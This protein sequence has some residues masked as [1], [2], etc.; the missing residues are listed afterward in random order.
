MKRV[1]YNNK[2]FKILDSYSIKSSNN[3][4]TF[5]DIIIDFTG[6]TFADI[7]YKYQEIQIREAESEEEILNAGKVI[8]TGFL[9]TPKISNMKLKKKFKELTLTLLSPLKM[10][11]VRTTS[12]IGTFDTETAIRRILEP[13]IN[14]GFILKEVNGITGTI[15]TNFVLETIE[16][17]MNKVCSEKNVFWYI[18]AKKEI[19]VNSINYLFGLAP[20]KTIRETDDFRTLGLLNIEPTI[21]NTDYANVINFKN[22]RLIYAQRYGDTKYPIMAVN[23]NIKNG[24]VI[25]FDNPIIIDEEH[26]RNYKNENEEETSYYNFRLSLQLANGTYKTYTIKLEEDNYIVD[27]HITFNDDDGDE[28]EIVLQRDSFFSN[29]ITGFKWNYDS[30][31]TIQSIGSLTALRY[32]TMKFMHTTEIERLKGVISKSGQIE[33][34]ID[35]TEKWTTLSQLIEYGRSLIIQN[36]NVINTVKLEFDQNPDLEIGDKIELDLEHFYTQNTFAVKD[37][38]YTYKNKLEQNWQITVKSADL[39]ST[40]IDIFRPTEKQENED[41]IDTVLLSE[42]V[43]EELKEVHTVSLNEAN[44]TL[45]FNL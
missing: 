21:E 39:I 18:N 29:L 25:T 41:K 22:V 26:L 24:D 27:E 7:P 23:K 14:D 4:V 11:T 36:S 15:S 5:N 20:K 43:E 34:T 3:V 45:N 12:L 17:A 10:A 31:A 13:L 37:I 9:D 44:H 2:T 33:K 42:F 40:Y 6:K 30:N 16:N 32:T 19:F 28:G 35:Y 1:V 38:S 8:F